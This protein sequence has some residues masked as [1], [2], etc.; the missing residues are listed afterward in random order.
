MSEGVNETNQTGLS[1][2]E[3][4]FL[5]VAVNNAPGNSTNASIVKGGLLI[6]LSHLLQQASAAAS[7]L[8][9]GQTDDE[10]EDEK[11]VA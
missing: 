5:L 3:L 4:D 10:P 8:E 1:I 11:K 7:A 6:K 2:E 9:E